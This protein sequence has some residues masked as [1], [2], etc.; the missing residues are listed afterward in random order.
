VHLLGSGPDLTSLD[1]ESLGRTVLLETGAILEGF[2]V[3]GGAADEGGGVRGSYGDG[4][5]PPVVRNNVIRGNTATG[6]GGGVHGA[7]HLIGNLIEQNSAGDRGG[8]AYLS[9]LH[10]DW[11]E[12]EKTEAR[13][14]T[15]ADN[16]ADVRGG[17][18]YVHGRGTVVDLTNN[19][20]H[21]N[22][23]QYGGGVSI[24]GGGAYYYYFYGA[25]T[26]NVIVG[27]TATVTNGVGGLTYTR[28][29]Y[30]PY[31]EYFD[32]SINN[33]VAENVGGGL[34]GH[35]PSYSDVWGN[36][37]D[38]Y[39]DMDDPTG[40]QG[41]ISADPLFRDKAAGDFRLTPGSPAIDSGNPG[42]TVD[43][44]GIPRPQ[45][46]DLNGVA[47]PDMG[48]LEERGEVENLRI[49]P[50]H[51]TFAW[52]ARPGASLYHLYRGDLAVLRAGGDYTQDP[53]EVSL[54]ERWCGLGAPQQTDAVD[55]PAGEASFYL[56]TPVG[57]QE[58]NLGFDTAKTART[59]AHP[60]P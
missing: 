4:Q 21:G 11:F 15:I 43:R 53:G 7:V 38:N 48:A 16:E 30:G 47:V 25:V 57:D 17:G 39:V 42:E 27:N 34:R 49:A 13:N 40:Q 1:G 55:P 20:I 35:T 45:D 2:T 29:Y 52:D 54:A 14:N 41:N 26:S 50:D 59:N 28:S 8:G 36:T 60:C 46:G 3:T 37:P 22:R 19:L 32:L 10:S 44:D 12:Y 18:L 9:N 24:Y 5:S 56:A 6:N 23:A 33:I 58:G 31:E 51:D